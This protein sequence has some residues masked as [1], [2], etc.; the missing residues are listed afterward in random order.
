MY[1]LDSVEMT[2][3]QKR[4][5]EPFVHQVGGHTSMMK[6]DDTT[7]CKPLISQEQLFYE[8]L[9]QEMKPFTPQYKGTISVCLEKDSSGQLSLVA[10]PQVQKISGAEK[11]GPEA[12][13]MA[14]RKHKRGSQRVMGSSDHSAGII[15]SSQLEGSSHDS[16]YTSSRALRLAVRICSGNLFQMMDG[17]QGS[18]SE[19]NCFNP[20]SLQCHREQLSRMCSESKEK[21]LYRFLLLENVVSQFKCPSILDLKMGTRQHGDDASEEKKARHIQ[22]CEQSTSA[23]LG[24]RICGMQIYQPES[25][26]FLCRNKYYGRSLSTEGFKQSLYQFLHNGTYLRKDLIEPVLLR[27][28]ALK[29]VIEKQSSYRFY[30]SSLL[31]IYDGKEMKAEQKRNSAE[32]QM[33]KLSCNNCNCNL[34]SDVSPQ[35]GNG[36]AKIEVHMID[37]AHT[38]YKDFQSYQ[39]THDG[40][41]KGYIFGLDNLIQIL[42]TLRDET[43]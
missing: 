9:P 28:K 11:G 21:K 27:L 40:P 10:C 5:L 23:S 24:V 15:E 20:W 25:G 42:Q 35:P 1:L 32:I 38:T 29:A 12:P 18:N 16:S 3:P 31:I 41:D 2:D 37:F 19:K 34:F 22:K 43:E 8:S 30:S 6:Y 26:H 7:I 13:A 4:I 36:S 33:H 17:N 39:G 14:K